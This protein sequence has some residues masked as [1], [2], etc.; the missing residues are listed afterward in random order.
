MKRF[1]LGVAAV[2][3]GAQAQAALTVTSIDI[4][5]RVGRGQTTAVAVNYTRASGTAP[6]TVVADV[7][8]LLEI[9][10]PL[11][12][13]CTLAGAAGSAQTL[14]CAGVD[15]G[16]I[17]NSGSFSFNVRGRSLGGGNV[18]ASNA[19][20]PASS[21]SDSFSVVS[22]GDLTVAKSIAPGNVLINGQTATF[23]LTPALSGDTV[24]AGATVTVTDQL[25]GTA[26]EFSLTG[27]TAAG[28][29]CNSVVDAN[30]TRNVV[31]TVT[32]PLASLGP[33]TV[34]GRPTLNGAGGL[35]NTASIAAD[36]VNYIDIASNNNLAQVSF[37]VEPGSDPRPGGSFPA[38]AVAGSA[39][40][41]SVFFVN[42]GPQTITGGQLRVAVPTGFTLGVLPAGCSNSGAGTVAGISGTVLTCTSGTVASGGSQGFLLPLTVPATAQTGNFGLEVVTGPGGSLPGGLTDANTAN[43]QA[44]VPYTIVPPYADLSLSKAKTSGPL[45]VGAAITNTI[46]VTN[47]GIA[48]AVY[49]AAS[50]ATPLRV[51]D[52]MSNDEEF[53]LAGA[54]WNCTD[55]GAN[56]GGAGQRRVVCLADTAATLA[57][58]GSITLTLNTRVA[59]TLGGPV[60]LTNTACTGAQALSLLGLPATAG[61]Q[62]PDGNQN[63]GTDC[64]SR[65]S[66]GTPVISGQAQVS[67]LK[68]SSRDG[69]NWVDAVAAAPTV[70]ATDT[71]MF[72]RIT[73]TT[74][75][76]AVNAVQQ[77]IPTLNL[78]DVLPGVLN[79]V[80]PG[81]GIPAHVTPGAVVS[82]VVLAG[83]AN[84]TCPA[85]LAAGAAELG[86]NFSNVAPGSRIQVTVRLERPFEAGSFTNTASLSS[87]DAIL[88]AA[89]GG[90]LA[91][92]A[93][94]V[95]RGR[96]DPAITA[97]T[98]S[99]PNSATEPRVGQ[100]ISYTIL[101]RNLGPNGVN[102]PM[103][104]SDTLDP[105]RF[106]VLGAQA[107]GS[108]TAPA[109][110]CSVVVATGSVSCSTGAG[111]V[112][113]RYDFY[114]VTVQARVLK[115]TG[116]LPTT[117][118]A[119]VSSFTNV[120]TVAL[121][122]AQNCEFRDGTAG[123]AA[124]NDAAATSNNSGSAVV[125]IKVPLVDLSQKK[126]RVLPAGQSNFGFGDLL[127]YRF[128]AQNN[129]PS[130]AE[131]VIVTDRP[132]APAGYSL[133]LA[134]VAAVNAVAAE[135]GLA[136]DTTKSLATLSCTQAGG[137]A[138]VVCRLAAGVADFLDPSTE[139][140][141]DL[142]FTL[143]GA[144]Q[145]VSVGNTALICADESANYESAGACSFNL[146]L[147]GNNS[148][149]VND[150]VF[151]K[152]DLALTKTRVTPSPVA[153]NQPV[154]YALV[155]RNLGPGS[156][157]QLRV[158]DQ[159]PANFEWLGSGSF[160]PTAVGGGFAGLAI[161][162]VSCTATPP[163]LTTAGQQQTVNCVLDGSFP[164]SAD[165]TNTVT[166]RLF[167]RPKAGFFTG[168]YLSDRA[169]SAAVAP[170]VDNTI[171]P[172]PLSIDINP[173]NN[174]SS[175]NTQVQAA[176]LAGT[177]FQD[178]ER[179]AASAGTPQAAA[180]E[181][182]L[183]GVAVRL[184]GSD[185]FGNAIDLATTTD[186]SG[187]YSFAN[188]PPAG[189]SGYT[190]TQTQPAGF[191]NGPSA[192]PTVGPDAPTAA[193]SY[194]GGGAAGNS[195]YSGITLATGTAGL[196]YN[197]PEVRQ[198]SLAGFVYIDGNA[199][200]VR[201][202]ATDPA[203]ANATVRLLN[204]ANG[205]LVATT[206]TAADGS[207][208]FTALDPLVVYTLEEPLPTAPA[209]LVNGPVNAGLI[210]GAACASG[211]TP[212]PA[213]T[214]TGSDRITTIDLGAGTDGSNFNFGE[215]QV[216]VISGTVYLDRDRS[217]TLSPTPADG[218]LSGVTVRL[219]QGATCA[220][221]TVLQTTTTDASGNY[222]F[223]GV[224]AGADYLLC[225]QQPAGYASAVANPGAAGSVVDSNTVRINSLAPAGSAGNHF[226]EWAGSLVGSV[227]VDYTAGSAANTDNGVRDPGETGIANVPVTLSGRDITG[228]LVSLATT[229][230]ASGNYAFNDLLQSDAAG[231]TVGEGAIPAASG[232]YNDGRDSPGSAGGS[233][234][235]NDT[236]SGVV[237]GA[238]VQAAGYLFGELPIAPITGTVYIDRNG[239]GQLGSGD[240]R[241]AGVVI[242]LVLGSSCSGSTA[243]TTTTD[244]SGNYTF[245]GVSA[246][247]TYTLC[248]TQPAGYGDGSTNPGGSGS[249]AAANTI[250]LNNLPL[251]GSSGNHFGERA[252]TLAGAVYLDANNDGIRQ[253]AEAGLAGVVITLNGSDVSGNP[254][255]RSAT[256]DASG[257]YRFDDLLAAGP[258]GY[259]VTEQT[260]QP[261]VGGVA[262]LNGRTA[263]GT[264]S[265]AAGGA[266]NGTPT[267][268]ASTPSA[269]AAIALGA[270]AASVD[271]NFGEILPV[272]LSGTV[273]ID[274]DNNG[275]QNA[276]G[277]AGLPGV[278]LVLSGTDDLGNPVSLTLT[279]AAD[280]SYSVTHQRP[281]TYTLTQPNQPAGT[282]NGLT[283]PGTAGGTASAVATLP[284]SITGIVLTTPGATASANNFAEIPNNSTLS[285]RVW[286]D[287]N[288]NGNLDT[289]EAGI[290]GVVIELSG[291]DSSGRTVARSTTTDASGNYS[292]DGLSP[293]SYTVRQPSQPAGT[294]NG[295]TV[296]GSNGGT[297]TA[298]ATTPSA[299]SAIN[300][301]VG[302]SASANNFG[303][304][305]AGSLSGRVYADNNNDGV[306]DAGEAGLSGVTLVLSG[307]DDLGNPVNLTLQTAADGSYSF[308]NLRPGTY[309][310]TQPVQPPGTVGGITSAGSL[311]GNATTPAV[312]LS[313]ITGIVLPPGGQAVNNN[314][315]ELV[316]SPD[317]RVSKR[318]AEPRFTV[319]FTGTYV[320]GVRNGGDRDTSGSY[321]VSDR[322]PAGLSL[323]ATPTGPG[324]VC[325]GAVAAS[326]FTCSSSAV[327]AA[328]A[329][330]GGEITA[331]VNVAPA[332]AAAAANAPLQNVV[333]VEGGGE[334]PARAPSVAEHEAFNG[335]PAALP[336]CTPAI[337]H[338]VCR[339]PTAV[340]LAA[341]IS[342]TVW[343]DVGNRARQLDGGDRRLAGWLVEVLDPATG[344]V[345][346]RATTAAD[347]S[348]RVAGLLPGVALAVRFRDPASGIVFGY[349]V[350]GDTVPGSSGAACNP[351]AAAAGG[352][353][354]CVGTGATPAL[355]VVLAPG[356]D[357]PQQSLPVD[358]SGVVYDSGLRQPVPGAVV[359][360]APLGAC[361][362]WNP[363][364]HLV[365]ATLGGYTLN[366]NA[367]AMT[368]GADGFYQYLFAPAAPASCTFTL[369][370]VPPAGYTFQSAAI[371]P[372]PGVLTPGGGP[373]STFAVQP[374]AT[375]PVGAVGGATVYFLSLIGGS[376][377][378][379]IIHNHIPL[380]PSLPTALSLAKTADKA[381]AEVGDSIRY[382]I[383]V[384]VA[385]GAAPR[386]TTVL[387]RL[388][389]GFT[390]IRGTAMA[391][392]VPI[393]DPTSSSPGGLGPL[394]A[395]NLGA[396]P[397]SK[398]LVLRYRVRVG[399]GAQQ[400]DG[401]NRARGHACG[402]PTACVDAQLQPL[403]GSVASNEGVFKV[404][405]G[406]GVF[407]TD[408]CVLG[409]IFVDCNGNHVQDT[410]ELGVP[411]VRLVMQDGTTLIS[412]SEGKYSV[413]G[414]PPRS[415]VLKVDALTL[416]RGSRLTTSSNRNLGDAG[417]LWLDLKNGELHRADFAEGSCSNTV[418]DQVKARRAQGEVRA[419]E[420][421]R[422][423]GPALRFDS[424]AHGLTRSS[425]PRQGTDSSNQQVPKPR[426]PV[427]PDA[428][429][430]DGTR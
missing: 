420:P 92:A 117:P 80:S 156:T 293:G 380:D 267:G 168:P 258:G 285:G 107:V 231:Y 27:I 403:P 411:G 4:P 390:Y 383:T 210:D 406:G 319:G 379:N 142:N 376:A 70:A 145:V 48:A 399:V 316:N 295:A 85:S 37:S 221:G 200:G 365:G 325:V 38:Q 281:G 137:N 234:A 175:A 202:A 262:T 212:A 362:G 44:L 368:V 239:D 82:T 427:A 273:F 54:G 371:P 25:P 401:I 194:A 330:G 382:S 391:G 363:A 153:I 329:A 9:T 324:W 314:F 332:A 356:Q 421:E 301:G 359:T 229:T 385:A 21:A 255:I 197:F 219:V 127:R 60:T 166:L 110:N 405:V 26:A 52:T 55:G 392:D 116:V 79:V 223:A 254:V 172:Q 367:V 351:A 8:A 160:T 312:A 198:P 31:C 186:A 72:W 315:G 174:G 250:T 190:L 353:S 3:L 24:P 89:V 199:N 355:T 232:S 2:L 211:C 59:A 125:D 276:P 157:T 96:T 130:R 381:A 206:T 375:P 323:A 372:Q 47:G 77:S 143:T 180:L 134:G 308:A 321:S 345:A 408:A 311:G 5:A 78:A 13:G 14:T 236:L 207:Y 430:S 73:V 203:V 373:G 218:R 196:N 144:S 275:V 193:G 32:G 387:D 337:E 225:Q 40:T 49:S 389:A 83:S 248:Q 241:I 155:L 370:V 326:S 243:A 266:A 272:V 93:A 84:G 289:T 264:V 302:G 28:Y 238:G 222:S 99:P 17:G 235:G 306:V 327:I 154:E 10:A 300:L 417:S 123:S 151:P 377:G 220:A 12:A 19:G 158:A 347:G 269:V 274:L 288:N 113:P 416:P 428:G 292:F 429:G 15:P 384:T 284:S 317:L 374:Q 50:G 290:A 118:G 63:N 333:L 179:G 138:D 112:V 71:A 35:V 39:Q 425:S 358:P 169:N 395:F 279:T 361:A 122:P 348:Y 413:C 90:Q 415:A 204:A 95:V 418:L 271:N 208:A 265:G 141:F 53:V 136:L 129:G 128:R 159:L 233:N 340:Q 410:E 86:C 299:L 46:V 51:V 287:S 230:D 69:V 268:V 74:P 163:A 242:R 419:P 407:T 339:T 320:I 67:V 217:S 350:N 81:A 106:L 6:E 133:A 270:G 257:N 259:T 393:A 61:P 253:G 185:A 131:G 369:S 57:V 305:P 328:G 215:V 182:R 282:S 162:S 245:S 189:G 164:G 191:V 402:A 152:T 1:L 167:A 115:P 216:T 244:A 91:D 409:K 396:M 291:T 16:A 336:V 184:T 342:G 45:A 201:D 286:L 30:A 75:S 398:Q 313:G 400:G 366:G 34:V 139:V 378:A 422:R 109:M 343:Y 94:L 251:A 135:G 102:G 386:Q 277:D 98:V 304:V 303:E 65:S 263:A 76:T 100:T 97:K 121:D 246:G 120:A 294:V 124:C 111:G 209:G 346:G 64:E 105:T 226:G 298:V 331:L 119:V 404:R 149:T 364:T 256:T 68:E 240:G 357:L 176:S 278:T 18:S 397:A 36:G 237:L 335:N 388:P 261:V 309:A 214:A 33:I 108:R 228:A 280:G 126:L 22:G 260:A 7:P 114:S 183:A 62:P 147:A 307:T 103:T 132:L 344:A 352:A 148:A 192:P 334:I 205:S 318:L 297:A 187:N 424:K 101:A 88:T 394:L 195:S 20:P 414:L 56:S 349:P 252:A 41:L 29:A 322:L 87:P 165:A 247:L 412:D 42:D 188:L 354:S 341:S 426:A 178:R 249:S 150:V 296:P 43:N 23:T 66:V 310:V 146:A 213:G 227:Y 177:V 338:N 161:T 423:G 360:L 171:P 170:G 140:N 58:G 224:A 104:V 11:P 173:A 181:P 283:L